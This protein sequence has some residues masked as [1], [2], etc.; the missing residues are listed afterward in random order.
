M[1]LGLCAS[2]PYDWSPRGSFACA[3][4]GSLD[5]GR[6]CRRPARR[7]QEELLDTPATAERRRLREFSATSERRRC[8]CWQAV[9]G[10]G[11]CTMALPVRDTR[12]G[13]PVGVRLGFEIRTSEAAQ[14]LSRPRCHFRLVSLTGLDHS[15]EVGKNR[16]TPIRSR[17][18]YSYGCRR[19]RGSRHYLAVVMP[20]ET[21]HPDRRSP[22]GSVGTPASR[23]RRL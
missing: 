19:R 20:R 14:P 7:R 13:A 4:R 12:R 21:G 3:G 2:W 8:F 15:R 9:A 11:G 6:G 22:R 10:N 18:C 1:R 23:G 5:A 16:S 17:G